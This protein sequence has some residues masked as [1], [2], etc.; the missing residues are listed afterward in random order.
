MTTPVQD[1]SVWFKLVMKF[2][3]YQQSWSEHHIMK[4]SGFDQNVLWAGCLARWRAA[5]LARDCILDYAVVIQEGPARTSRVAI[6]HPI[7]GTAGV[8]FDTTTTAE[9]LIY[10]N[11][12][13]D[14]LQVRME[15]AGNRHADRAIKG[16]PDGWINKKKYNSIPNPPDVVD[17]GNYTAVMDPA[18]VP[19]TEELFVYEKAPPYTAAQLSKF[20]Y[21]ETA[22]TRY[23]NALYNFTELRYPLLDEQGNKTGNYSNDPWRKFVYRYATSRTVGDPF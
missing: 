21:Y 7:M 12:P 2:F 14:G 13:G 4:G 22:I 18:A 8:K 9:V 20:V 11:T 5:I 15:S 6:D 17:F 3:C 16:I 19:Q 1:T 23:F 10:C